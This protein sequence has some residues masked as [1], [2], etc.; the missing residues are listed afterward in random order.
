[1][2]FDIPINECPHG[3]KLVYN[4][5]GVDDIFVLF[6]SS[7]GLEK[8][9]NY[10]NSKHRNIRITCEKV[11]CNNSMPVLDILFTTPTFSGVYSNFNSLI[12]E[13]YK[14]GLIHTLLFRT[15]LIVSDFSRFH[16]EVCHTK[17]ILKKNTFPTKLIAICIKNFPNKRLAEKPVIL[18]AKKK[19]LVIVL[20]FL[21]KVLLDL[22]NV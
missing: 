3:F 14:V 4:R 11:F 17:E 8:F 5:Y 18:T 22:G 7:D 20:P 6:R 19:N 1:M 9:K 2:H 15:F 16:L 12:S 21:G 13:Q 10:L